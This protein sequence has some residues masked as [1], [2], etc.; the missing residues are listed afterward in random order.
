MGEGDNKKKRD[1]RRRA[2][3]MILKQAA[4]IGGKVLLV[5]QKEVVLALKNSGLPANIDVAWYGAV[6]GRDH[7]RDVDGIILLGAP[8]PTSG[9]VERMAGA[10]S[11]IAPKPVGTSDGRYPKADAERL[12][13]KG[14]DVVSIPADGKRHP[15]DLAETMRQHV[16]VGQIIQA[17][18][19]GRGVRRGPDNPLR[20]VALTGAVLPFPVDR[21]L[22]EA[23]MA[24]THADLMIAEGGIAFED[25]TSAAAAYPDLYPSP[26]AARMAFSREQAAQSSASRSLIEIPIRDRYAVVA[27]R[28]A[29]H[30]LMD[31]P[32][33]ECHAPRLVA[34][35]KAGERQRPQRAWVHPA[36]CADPRSWV[37]AKLGPLARFE[38][39]PPE[40]IEPVALP[41]AVGADGPLM[42]SDIGEPRCF[43]RADTR[44]E[45]DPSRVDTGQN[46]YASPFVAGEYRD[47]APPPDQDN[48]TAAPILIEAA[49]VGDDADQAANLSAIPP[50][51]PREE[52]PPA[53]EVVAVPPDFWDRL[54]RHARDCG[55]RHCD[56]AEQWAGSSGC[57]LSNIE[58]GRRSMTTNIWADLNRFLDTAT[59]IQGTLL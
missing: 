59:P 17:A 37:E 45:A 1:K 56:V 48:W 32:I 9:Q 3:A 7:W 6:A 23:D 36:L 54:W 25:G 29:S 39:V 57:H 47:E 22:T 49:P 14:R 41:M 27:G 51:P 31:I 2:K 34:F 50:E 55:L 46:W 35:Q 26:G 28:G 8:E 10:L 13:R 20:V 52:G 5:G 40:A 58:Q 38:V 18:G 11:G 24:V 44:P 30:T 42:R 43:N 12:L 4:R 19:R 33:R 21:F 15:D 53:A 16:T